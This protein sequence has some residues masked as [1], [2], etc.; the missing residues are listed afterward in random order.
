M[1][2]LRLRERAG[3]VVQIFSSLP[4]A[5]S[6]LMTAAPRETALLIA[7]TL[8]SGLLPVGLLALTKPTVDAV[9]AAL[10]DSNP[11][12]WQRAAWLAVAIASLLIVTEVLAAWS[13]WLR[14]GQGERVALHVRG[15]VHAQ[16]ARV[17]MGFFEQPEFFDRLHRAR[18]ASAQR[19]LQ[20]IE[21]L[22]E[23]GRAGIALVGVTAI[24]A[25]YSIWLPL[26]LV[27]SM[28]PAM[29]SSLLHALREHRFAI[30]RT[31]EERHA[32]YFD[33]L[34]TDRAPAAE[35]RSF[36]LSTH[37]QKA[38]V[39]VRQRIAAGRLRLLRNE[40]FSQLLLLSLGLMVAAGG[41]LWMLMRASAGQGTLGDVA[42]CYQAFLQGSAL[43]RSAV[44]SLSQVYVG[45]LF[46]SDFF[47][48]LGLP[49]DPALQIASAG[50]SS[51]ERQRDQAPV[52]RFEGVHFRYPGCRGPA[53]NG[54]DLA[55][56]PAGINA[57]LGANGAGKS[58]L[59][60]LLCRYYEPDTGTV[61]IDGVDARQL[62]VD[63]V[64]RMTSVLFQDPMQFSGS[65]AENILPLDPDNH[66]AID[67]AVR[68]AC[69]E[70][71]VASLPDGLQTRLAVWFPG[72]TDLSGG[73]WQRLAMAR[74]FARDAPVLV[75]DEPTSAMDP[76]TERLWLERLRSSAAGRTVVL[77]TH[78]LTTAAAADQVHV[79]D[80][81][82][83]IESGSHD[84]LRKLGGTYARLWENAPALAPAA[85]VE[86]ASASS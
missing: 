25:S 27:L 46:L 16:S 76:W 2:S 40:S 33:W 29:V 79:M 72:G 14:A 10:S 9:A 68:A 81:G 51:G 13:A 5:L 67:A 69:A 64:R 6:L 1:A 48:F 62:P 70:S 3:N 44:A 65:L 75:L 49:A 11:A 18:D 42:L 53:L 52:I 63:A 74:A 38:F 55:I 7:V 36:G 57:V 41:V 84:E 45:A 28:A 73:E 66:V 4:R 80:A 82:R 37:F 39:E 20:I 60:K 19:P 15:L 59:V 12:N 26:L 43:A 23:I 56:L 32:A 54:L 31:V 85:G 24:L 61:Y 77:I 86:S 17:A 34:L 71:L 47:D 78:R 30:T 22:T 8:L 21:G 35:M 50:R 58:T 83:V